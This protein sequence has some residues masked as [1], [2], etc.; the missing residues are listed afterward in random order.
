M[1]GLPTILIVED[2]IL[3]LDMLADE[4][5]EAGFDVLCAATGEEAVQLLE[6][7]ATIDALLTDVRLPGATDGWTVARAARLLRPDLPVLYAT[8]FSQQQPD[9]VAGATLLRKPFVPRTA[10]EAIRA[11][12]V[13]TPP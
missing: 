8:G 2:E 6:S 11:Y 9:M 4:L 7:G 1:T 12:G 3:I 13:G 10:V 5:R